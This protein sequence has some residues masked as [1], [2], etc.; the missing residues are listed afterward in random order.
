[1]LLTACSLLQ[2]SQITS[3]SGLVLGQQY[4]FKNAASTTFLSILHDQSFKGHRAIVGLKN[5]ALDSQKVSGISGSN[6]NT[7]AD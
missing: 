2:A 4:Y 5:K 7:V 6:F 1:M 3:L